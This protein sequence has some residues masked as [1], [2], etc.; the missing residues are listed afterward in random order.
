MK[1]L[2]L[3]LFVFP[4]AL[5]SQVKSIKLNVKLEKIETG[6]KIIIATVTVVKDEKE[7][8]QEVLQDGRFEYKID[9]GS[10]YKI[11]FSK[12][13]Q[14][15]KHLLIDTRFLPKNAK[16]YQT[17]KV[18]MTYFVGP[19][20]DD[21]KFLNKTPVGIA[22]YDEQH[23]KLRWDYEYAFLINEKIGK[24]LYQL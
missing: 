15:T 6:D 7:I 24:V 11:Y 18:T 19:D 3:A 9:T 20:N 2:F 1:H 16:K 13:N 5:F 10:I 8:H 21:L 12:V 22:Q 23:K 4:F 17:L 14:T